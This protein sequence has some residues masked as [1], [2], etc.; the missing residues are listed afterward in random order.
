[1]VNFNLR[2]LIPFA[3]YIQPSF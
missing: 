2:F 3:R 1:M